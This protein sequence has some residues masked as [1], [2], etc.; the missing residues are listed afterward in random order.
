MLLSDSRNFVQL[1][2]LSEATWKLR[3][4]LLT[5][6]QWYLYFDI[7]Q[8]AASQQNI[9]MDTTIELF[10]VVLFNS[11]LV[12]YCWFPHH[13]HTFL[14][15]DTLLAFVDKLERE[16]QFSPLRSVGWSGR[17]E[18]SVQEMVNVL[19]SHGSPQLSSLCWPGWQYY[20]ITTDFTSFFL[21][22]FTWLMNSSWIEW[23]LWRTTGILENT[24]SWL[25]SHW[26]YFI[27]KQLQRKPSTELLIF[28]TLWLNLLMMKYLLGWIYYLLSLKWLQRNSFLNYKWWNAVFFNIQ[29]NNSSKCWQFCSKCLIISKVSE[30]RN[31]PPKFPSR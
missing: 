28:C 20:W 22:G 16:F 7:F 5:S 25:R 6:W 26:Q 17:H 4:E 24:E 12:I 18:H 1:L 27:G 23:T 29:E 30:E 9:S 8:S 13:C 19:L 3:L 31:I 2:F 11:C 21:P 14:L 10:V 15:F